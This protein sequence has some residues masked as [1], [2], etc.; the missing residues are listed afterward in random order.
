MALDFRFERILKK[1]DY[2]EQ[3]SWRAKRQFNT[4]RNVRRNFT[5]YWNFSK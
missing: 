3:Y 4:M 5:T 2:S 1:L